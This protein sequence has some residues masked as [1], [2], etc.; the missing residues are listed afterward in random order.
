MTESE[1][2]GRLSS[3]LNAL[4]FRRREE[5]LEDMRRHFEEGRA[6]GRDEHELAD[7]LGDPQ[8]LARDYLSQAGI[9]PDAA[10]RARGAAGKF[11]AAVGMFFFN[12]CLGIPLLI[13]LWALWFSLAM[14]A[15]A[16]ILSGVIA[17][18]ATALGPFVPFIGS[19]GSYFLTYIFVSIACVSGG[20]LLGYAA[21]R[22]LFKC[23]RSTGKYIRWNKYAVTGRR[24]PA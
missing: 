5:I 9:D 2:M 6:I 21:W 1:F 20:I 11:F 3:G 16:F 12:I 7:M 23:S 15:L 4:P 13:T 19:A 14:M 10:P 22:L 18:A 17:F 24:N 8:G